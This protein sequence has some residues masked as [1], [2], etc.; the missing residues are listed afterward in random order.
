ML[1]S[2]SNIYRLSRLQPSTLINVCLLSFEDA[3]RDLREEIENILSTA[4]I[5]RMYSLHAM[6]SSLFSS[7]KR[8]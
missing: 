2:S 3:S 6:Q 1:E 4:Y 7:N 5:Y 8:T